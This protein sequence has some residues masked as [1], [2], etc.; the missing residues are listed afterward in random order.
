MLLLSNPKLP[1]T[2]FSTEVSTTQ[3]APTILTVLGL[4]PALL[5]AVK[6]EGTAV[7]PGIPWTF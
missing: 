2:T 4:N 7:L 5:D 1:A 6:L 3:V